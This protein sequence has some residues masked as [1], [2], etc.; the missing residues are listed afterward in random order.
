L[1]PG[2]LAAL[3]AFWWF[4]ALI[5][6]E[7]RDIYRYSLAYWLIVPDNIR[8]LPLD[9]CSELARYHYSA[10]DG[11]KPLMIARRCHTS[12]PTAAIAYYRRLFPKWGYRFSDQ[13]PT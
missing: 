3:A 4:I 12:D 2:L 7:S 9:H 13:E 11:P 5:S 10:G 8:R 1:S 6:D